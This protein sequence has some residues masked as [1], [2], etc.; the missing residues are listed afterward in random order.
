M[1]GKPRTVL[2]QG[3]LL[4]SLCWEL[5]RKTF[6]DMWVGLALAWSIDLTEALKP[7]SPVAALATCVSKGMAGEVIHNYKAHIDISAFKPIVL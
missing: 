2:E 1:M 4:L 5:E 7:N 3:V 6:P